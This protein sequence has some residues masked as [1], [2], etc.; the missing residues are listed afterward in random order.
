MFQKEETTRQWTP[1][2]SYGREG[3]DSERCKMTG[4]STMSGAKMI[5]LLTG[6]AEKP[7]PI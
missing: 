7:A 3:L 5:N 1:N 6:K 4:S 2:P